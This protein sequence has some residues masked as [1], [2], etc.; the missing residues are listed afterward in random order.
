MQPFLRIGGRAVSKTMV[1]EARLLS[2]QATNLRTVSDRT[3]PG[4][5][6]DNVREG[7]SPF[8]L[9]RFC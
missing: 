4:S 5:H 2:G 8:R 1:K 7:G 3:L 6:E 9:A